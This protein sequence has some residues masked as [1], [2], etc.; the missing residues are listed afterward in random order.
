MMAKTAIIFLLAG[1]LLVA[2][3]TSGYNNNQS[4]AGVS[5]NSGGSAG[6]NLSKLTYEPFTKEKYDAAKDS[7][8]IIFLE[9]YANWCPTCSVQKPLIEQAF[10]EI[11]NPSI[12]GFQVNFNDSDTDADEI[13]LAKKFGVIYQHT[14]VIVDSKENILLKSLESW[15]KDT[16]IQKLNSV[17]FN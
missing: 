5:N 12:A 11:N 9:F 10:R 14:H 17:G 15:S 7:G 6:S 13:A 4:N 3:C 2:G 1:V 16:V 8:K